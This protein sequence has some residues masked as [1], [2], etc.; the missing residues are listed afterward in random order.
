[1]PIFATSKAKIEHVGKHNPCNDRE[2]DMMDVKWN[3]FEFTHRLP[4]DNQLEWRY[5]RSAS[6]RVGLIV[7]RWSGVSVLC[8]CSGGIA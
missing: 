2:T 5:Y 7:V 3:I 8:K 6:L 4:E 1:M